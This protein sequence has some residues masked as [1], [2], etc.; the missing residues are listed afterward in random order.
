[1]Q[2]EAD[3]ASFDTFE[4]MWKKDILEDSISLQA[5]LVSQYKSLEKHA[6]VQKEIIIQQ[7]A[8]TRDYNFLVSLQ[9][10]YEA[11]LAV[12]KIIDID[13][14]SQDSKLHYLQIRD[15]LRERI[16]FFASVVQQRQNSILFGES[17]LDSSNGQDQKSKKI[18]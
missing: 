13:G 9:E 16:E 11:T 1:M 8:L 4:K 14:C 10:R 18:E 3:T 5:L 2:G 7:K 17:R 6:D 15:Q 12:L